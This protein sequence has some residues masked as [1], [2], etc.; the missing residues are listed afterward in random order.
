MHYST[1]F[2]PDGGFSPSTEGHLTLAELLRKHAF[3]HGLAE[4]QIAN[5][6]EL[7]SEVAFEENEVILV[8]GQRSN[9][10]FLVTSGSVAVELRTAQ[11]A[12]CVQALGPGHV[13]GWSSLL[14][15][16]DTL[17][18]VRARE[19]TRALRL[20]G[21]ALKSMCRMDTLLGTEILQRTL[22]VVAG[23][24]KATEIRFAEMCGVRV[25][26]R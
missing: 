19:R 5:L 14:D 4:A 2:G 22:G 21:E 6:A 1:T 12:V 8:D 24:V 23:R 11:Y 20:E 10:F 25:P 17:F 3:T 26:P 16:Q 18:Q 9:A 15:H 13:F 7:A